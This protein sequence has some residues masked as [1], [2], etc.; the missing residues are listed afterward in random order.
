MRGL[1]F[2]K[3][4][5]I[6]V[7]V[8]LFIL[9]D[10]SVLVLNFYMSFEIADDAVGVNLAG[11]Q[12]MLSQRMMKSLLD[13]RYSINDPNEFDRS[14]KELIL[15]RN[16]FD[17][18]LAAFDKGGRIKSADD[19]LVD[20]SPV[21]SQKSIDSIKSAY[22]IWTPYLKAIDQV[23]AEATSGKPAA[24]NAMLNQWLDEAIIF[25]QANNL[26]LLKL[27]NDL[28]VDQEL[29]ATSKAE[30]L[31]WIQTVGIT[32]AIINFFIIMFHFLAQ[33]R[34][35]D[36]IIDA[37]REETTNILTTVN[38]G[39]FLLDKDLVIGSQ[40]SK[41]LN[42]IFERDNI[43]GL[44]FEALMNQLVTD[45]ELKTATSFINL[46]F[47]KKVKEKLI[48][49]LNP[50]NQVEIHFRN[51]SGSYISKYLKFDFNKVIG[52]ADTPLIL[53]TVTDITRQTL[54]AK[55]LEQEKSK[56]EDQLQILSSIIH[57]PAKTLEQFIQQAYTTFETVNSHLRKSEITQQA[58]RSKIDFIFNEIHRFKGESGALELNHFATLSHEF[59]DS[60]SE[61]RDKPELVGQ[62]FIRL[63]VKLE[64]LIQ[65]TQNVEELAQKVAG[66]NHYQNQDTPSTTDTQQPSIS[67][68]HL[69][70]MAAELADRQRKKVKLICTGLSEILLPENTYKLVNTICIQFIKNSITHGVETPFVRRLSK[71]PEEARIDVRLSRIEDNQIELTIMDNGRGIDTEQVKSKAVEKGLAT[72]EEVSRWG[73]DKIFE[74][75]S[76]SGFST[77]KVVT[78]DAGRGVG[79]NLIKE[80]IENIGGK[81]FYS[82]QPGRF[83]CFIVS[84]PLETSSTKMHTDDEDGISPE[85][86]GACVA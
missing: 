26:P 74:M 78:Q 14:I 28:T 22:Q 35:S 57:T 66:I 13:S 7:S 8:A 60:L 11:R 64:E 29:V 20:L 81:L 18:T 83:C 58:Y 49:D 50:L 1:D 45:K 65:Y 3:Y 6:I 84:L 42:F 54:L 19:S 21:E 2:G 24:T 4:K 73:K 68:E 51:Q 53:V 46:M 86:H 48:S 10:A 41:E 76:R 33:L 67:W 40:H 61:L 36:A 55:E 27:M 79:M 80:Q 63:T 37:A 17:S 59:E 70:R 56:S 32:L 69:P 62:D 25:G 30:T 52:T 72:E 82:T 38:E 34:R 23:L 77:A 47:E 9:L 71:K 5:G 31:R 39:L 16:L 15:T 85:A 44:T 43:S 75:I 12:R